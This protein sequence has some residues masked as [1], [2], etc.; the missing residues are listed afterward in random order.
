[1]RGYEELQHTADVAL[2]VWGR[3]LPELFVAAAEG[4][5]ALMGAPERLDSERE[6]EL[7]AEDLEA[8]LV[9]WLNELIY[10]RDRYQELYS[11]FDVQVWPSW[12]L[13][14]VARGGKA[15]PQGALIKAATY[16]GLTIGR[17]EEG[18]G[19]VAEIVFDT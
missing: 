1:L 19:F 2:R 18:E 9:D 5:F 3:T 15:K 10:L 12:R 13:H 6:L 4:M 14:G 17:L 11:S 16:H 7:E 8:L